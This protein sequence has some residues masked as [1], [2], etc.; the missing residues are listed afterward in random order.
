[1]A[2]QSDQSRP[3]VLIIVGDASEMLDTISLTRQVNVNYDEL[4]IG[5]SLDDVLG[6]VIPEPSSM[7]LL[8]LAGLGLLRRRR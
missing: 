8:G 6:V 7:S 4:R 2:D 3:S 1:M 5:T